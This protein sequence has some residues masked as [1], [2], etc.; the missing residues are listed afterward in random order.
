MNSNI[1]DLHAGRYTNITIFGEN[2]LF[3][4]LDPT[5]KI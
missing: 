3:L 4:K 2:W 1:A 5:D